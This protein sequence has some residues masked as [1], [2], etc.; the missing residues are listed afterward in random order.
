MGSNH[1]LAQVCEWVNA[2]N[3]FWRRWG[4]SWE[5]TMGEG[6]KGNYETPRTPHWGL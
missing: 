4:F 6:K 5:I 1:C 2:V 3:G